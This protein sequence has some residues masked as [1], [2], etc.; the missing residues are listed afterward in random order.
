MLRKCN[1][2]KITKDRIHLKIC[3]GVIKRKEKCKREVRR[4]NRQVK[5]DYS[6]TYSDR[7]C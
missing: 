6:A 2:N 7:S 5:I 1:C 4:E 3:L